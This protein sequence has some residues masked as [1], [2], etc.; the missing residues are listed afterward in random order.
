MSEL[1]TSPL[2]AY[3]AADV[4]EF[5]ATTPDAILG[6][7]TSNSAFAI[8][9][10]QRDAW[11][12]Q[13]EVLKPALEGVNGK[14]FLEFIVPRIGSRIDAVLIAGPAIFIL[15]FKVGETD[16]KREDLNQVWD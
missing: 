5:I 14:I 2:N 6:H 1:S 13:I 15:E 10:T 7:I 9:A 3:Y 4:G 8:D 16:F 12:A 11:V